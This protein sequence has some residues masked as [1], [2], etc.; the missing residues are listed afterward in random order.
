M[1][2]PARTQAG[3]TR[4]F[5][6]VGIG[7]VVPALPAFMV[8]ALGTQVRAELDLT[9]SA[10]GLIVAVLFVVSALAGPL[11]GRLADRFGERF[12]VAVGTVLSFL[13]LM[14]IGL[15]AHRW[16]DLVLL[17]I[18]GGIGIALVD[19]GLAR[20]VAGRVPERLRGLVFG[21]KESSIPLATM[22]AGFAVPLIAVTVGWRWAVTV[23][24]VP[25]VA[26]MALLFGRRPPRRRE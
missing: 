21:V 17:M 18:C 14:G 12:A 22:A 19:P 16:S 3:S 20:M 24:I 23:A 1:A 4:A 7:L 5:V 11:T 13:A 25:F 9:E 10:L 8:G 2:E 26:V 15:V 6:I